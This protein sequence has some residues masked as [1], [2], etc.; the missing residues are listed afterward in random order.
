MM[1]NSLKEEPVTLGS[2]STK[3]ASLRSVQ[4]SES[5]SVAP[6]GLEFTVYTRLDL[7]LQV[8]VSMPSIRKLLCRE[9]SGQRAG[10]SASL[11]GAGQPMGKGFSGSVSP[12]LFSFRHP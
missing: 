8:C 9:V 3:W 2:H 4:V 6:D 11:P 1:L 12:A 7:R 5:H 10:G